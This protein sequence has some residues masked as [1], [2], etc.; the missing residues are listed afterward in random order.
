MC[1]SGILTATLS[2]EVNG[3]EGNSDGINGI[4]FLP[5]GNFKFQ[6]EYYL[7]HQFCLNGYVHTNILDHLYLSVC[8]FGVK[9]ET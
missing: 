4:H 2:I 5:D 6:N 3:N 7:P 9:N 1:M 8:R